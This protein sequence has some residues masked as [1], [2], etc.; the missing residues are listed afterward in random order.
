[1]MV[2][3]ICHLLKEHYEK[4]VLLNKQKCQSIQEDMDGIVQSTT[5][6]D[7][8]SKLLKEL[9]ANTESEAKELAKELKEK[10]SRKRPR[11][12]DE[13]GPSSKRQNLDPNDPESLRKA[14]EAFIIDK[15]Y[16]IAKH[17]VQTPIPATTPPQIQTRPTGGRGRGRGG[18]GR[19]RGRRN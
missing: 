8:A 5:N 4:L 19:G 2:L 7:A 11:G 3:D 13:A 14:F 10:G 16:I 9:L 6:K 17:Y 18:R 1:M 12:D 15:Q